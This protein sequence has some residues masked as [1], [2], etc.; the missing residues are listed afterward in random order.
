ME[1]GLQT[2]PVLHDWRLLHTPEAPEHFLLVHSNVYLFAEPYWGLA[3]PWHGH[4]L[5]SATKHVP[6]LMSNARNSHVDCMHRHVSQ[7]KI[8]PNV[9]KAI[10]L[11]AGLVEGSPGCPPQI[12]AHLHL[13]H[14]ILPRLA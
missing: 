12:L 1:A 2:S 9:D 6:G 7:T 11:A 8:Y 10:L 13:R 5:M 4:K 3:L 14:C